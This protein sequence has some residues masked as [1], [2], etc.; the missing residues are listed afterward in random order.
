MEN[1]GGFVFGKEAACILPIK[2]YLVADSG[3]ESVK[4]G[5]VMKNNCLILF[6]LLSLCRWMPVSAFLPAASPEVPP[7]RGEKI[8]LAPEREE[9]QPGDTLSVSGLVVEA[10][11]FGL[12]YSRYVHV[13]M[14]DGRDSLVIRQKLRCEDGRFCAR[15]PV[16]TFQMPGI[17]YVRAYTRLMRN[18]PAWTFPVCAVGIGRPV[19]LPR[20]TGANRIDSVHFY[21]E[22]GRLVA[23]C[24]QVVVFD[25]RDANGRPL[26]VT[27]ELV[28]GRDSLVAGHLAT[29]A[30]GRGVIRFI[31]AGET[32]YTLR[33][34]RSP[35]EAYARFPLPP[36]DAAVSIRMNINRGRLRYG[37]TAS[38]EWEGNYRFVLFFRGDFSFE[39]TLSVHHPSGIADISG[40]P[41]GIYA[42]VLLDPSG[43]TV[44]E[45]LIFDPGRGAA[46]SSVL[47]T[48][49]E[50]YVPGETARIDWPVSL[51]LDTA[52]RYLIRFVRKAASAQDAEDVAHKEGMEE[53]G[54]DIASYLWLSSEL[55]TP[56]AC[57]PGCRLA[58]GGFDLQAI[59]RLLIGCRWRRRPLAGLLQESPA[60]AYLPETVMSLGGK[61]ESEW[62]NRLK[63][64][65]M[66]ALDNK[67][68]FTYT[69]EIT[70]DSRFIMGVDD[71]TEGHSFFIQAYNRKGKSYNFRIYPDAET[72]P[73]V[74]NPLRPFWEQ[75]L[76]AE[77]LAGNGREQALGRYEK[78]KG[79]E[80]MRNYRLKEVEVTGRVRKKQEPVNRYYEPFRLTEEML[81]RNVYSDL[82]PYFDR[83]MGL[84]VKKVSL[85]M[86]GEAA[87]PLSFRYGLF[88]TRGVSTLKISN[89]PYSYQAD[90]MPVL[91]DGSLIDTHLVLTTLSP[92]NVA[93][94]E[95]LTP[96]RALSY[97]SFGFNGAVLITTRSGNGSLFVSKGMHYHP[98]GLSSLATPPP[99]LPCRLRV[100]D[101]EGVYLIVAEGIDKEG[102]PFRFTRT[103]EVKEEKR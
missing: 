101:R 75:R 68:G 31:P 2:M 79:N 69:G 71:F 22:G 53:E 72:F 7:L 36:A 48:D 15:I 44:A 67:T 8:Y 39:D 70:P 30:D 56:L 100:P 54:E 89:D 87:S 81:R 3:K 26:Q 55:E 84:K 16:D 57:H 20:L 88:T 12:P 45:R 103:I 102:N 19:N 28:D 93:S 96:G 4:V 32:T 23:G 47:E 63:G 13:E 92:Q 94:I 50:A 14:F 98:E 11:H 83:L 33:L 42:G 58:D 17:Y 74:V 77:V 25:V 95:R 46:A 73:P 76:R 18:A 1:R 21:P 49:R 41:G 10:R 35:S 78:T 60:Y 61:V 62:G 38:A 5:P 91:L 64:G 52:A 90:E 6:L 99:A 82:V 29:S 24:P 27:G 37:L 59:D 34:R 9:I 51:P 40:Q 85:D 43:Q 86:S 80:G 97:T 66:V 65:N